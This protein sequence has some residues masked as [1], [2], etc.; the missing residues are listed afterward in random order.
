MSIKSNAGASLIETLV[1]LGILSISFGGVALMVANV[2][3][4][5]QRIAEQRQKLIDR[6]FLLKATQ[7]PTIWQHS[8]KQTIEKRL[9]GYQELEQCYRSANGCAPPSDPNVWYDITLFDENDKEILAHSQG[10]KY[11]VQWRPSCQYS[12]AC[13]SPLIHIKA[14]IQLSDQ[15]LGANQ[16]AFEMKVVSGFAYNTYANFCNALGGEI[17]QDGKCVFSFANKQCNSGEIVVSLNPFQCRP[18]MINPGG[19]GADP[20]NTVRIKSIDSSGNVI[21]AKAF[22]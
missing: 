21:C 8:V 22:N 12:A 18:L 13:K 14:Q 20:D 10:F 4:S 19:C 16:V 1:A 11:K 5:N 3:K 6:H 2:S 15:S 9:S 7:S 17:N